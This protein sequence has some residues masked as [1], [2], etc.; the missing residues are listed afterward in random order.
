MAQGT[1]SNA[2]DAIEKFCAVGG[3]DAAALAV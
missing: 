3:V 1:G 2:R